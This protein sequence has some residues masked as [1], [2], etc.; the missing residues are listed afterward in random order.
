MYYGTRT[1]AFLTLPDISSLFLDSI[2]CYCNF[3]IRIANMGCEVGRNHNYV[4]RLSNLGKV[5]EIL[6]LVLKTE[7]KSRV[8]R[9]ILI[10]L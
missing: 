1:Q 7:R 9:S 5:K 3:G 10:M 6:R 4:D 8:M 2:Y